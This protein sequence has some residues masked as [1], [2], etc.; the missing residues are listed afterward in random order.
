MT[1]GNRVLS[2]LYDLLICV[3]LLGLSALPYSFAED[4]GEQAE[5]GDDVREE[6]DKEDDLDDQGKK[7]HLERCLRALSRGKKVPKGCPLGGSSS[8]IA[9]GDFNGDGFGDL[10]V[11]VPGEETPPGV[12]GAGAVNIIYGSANGLTATDANVPASRFWSQGSTGVPDSSEPGDQFGSALAAG[13]FNGDNFSDLAIGVPGENVTVPGFFGPTTHTDAGGVIVIYGSSQGLVAGGAGVLPARFFDF[14]QGGRS[15][16]LQSDSRLG[17]SLAWGDFNRDGIGDLAIGCQFCNDGFF[18]PSAGAVWVLFGDEDDGLTTTGNQFWAQSLISGNSTGDLEGFGSS[19]AAGDFNRDGTSDLAI[20][21]PNDHGATIF[22]RTGRVVVL[23]GSTTGGLTNVGAQNWTP[24]FSGVYTCC[25]GDLRFGQSLAAGDFNG[26]VHTDLAIGA[27]GE[28]LLY[29]NNQPSQGLNAGGVGV[30]YGSPSGLTSQFSQHWTQALIGGAS[31]RGD[32]FG[33][34]LAAGDFNGD[35]RADLAIGVS[36]EGQY[37]GEVNVIYGSASGLGISL[38]PPQVFRQGAPLADAAESGDE[39]GGSLTA[40]NFGRNDVRCL[41]AFPPAPPVCLTFPTADLAVGAQS[42]DVGTIDDAGAVHVIY[43]S[44]SN[45]GLTA[46]NNQ[47][48]TQNSAG[49]PGGAEE[50]D[51]FGRALY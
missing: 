6:A 1:T 13:E 30:M 4:K 37:A 14:S 50:R 32:L 10:A 5:A 48:W 15:D 38:H 22:E 11:G 31:E 29:V 2:L 8:G 18:G 16:K 41:P 23:Y 46:A 33:Q 42:E 12:G 21:V 25:T 28:A 19:L 49:V 43:G 51:H 47:L 24:T 17:S 35:G 20:G 39:F 27:P 26:D 44:F 9:K 45:N 7:D 3:G 34:A 40:W 36:G